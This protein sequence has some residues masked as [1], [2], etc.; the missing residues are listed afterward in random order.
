MV[1]K[2]FSHTVA[3]KTSL[4]YYWVLANIPL[5]ILVS[6]R[7]EA[8]RILNQV[9]L[10]QC[11]KRAEKTKNVGKT[12]VYLKEIKPFVLKDEKPQIDVD[13]KKGVD[14]QVCV[15]SLAQ[16]QGLVNIHFHIYTN[17]K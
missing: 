12:G 14:F 3:F 1:I 15:G 6:K 11:I 7:V 10:L 13:P 16:L 2:K 8:S 4:V 5:E 9:Q 17:P